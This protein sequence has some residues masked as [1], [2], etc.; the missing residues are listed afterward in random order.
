MR[1]KD[2]RSRDRESQQQNFA[3]MFLRPAPVRPSPRVRAH[4]G[5]AAAPPPTFYRMLRR[6]TFSAEQETPNQ[7]VRPG[8]EV[9]YY[10]LQVVWS[11]DVKLDYRDFIIDN[12]DLTQ[13][14]ANMKLMGS[15]EMMMRAIMEQ[16]NIRL[17]ELG[18]AP[19]ACKIT[20]RGSREEPTAEAYLEYTQAEP[21]HMALLS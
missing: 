9:Y 8:Q 18:I 21:K 17:I 3:G 11:G 5:K 2:A 10:T 15:G 19:L 4:K 1:D 7:Y 13:F 16:V 12:G 20:V 14:I 6:G